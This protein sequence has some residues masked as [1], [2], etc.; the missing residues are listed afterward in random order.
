MANIN[1]MSNGIMILQIFNPI[2]TIIEIKKT[3]EKL[4]HKEVGE[5]LIID[6]ARYKSHPDCKNLICFVYDPERRI[7][8]PRGIENDLSKTTD[9]LGV[10]VFIRPI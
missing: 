3:R 9:G 7:K 5:Q 1:I 8:N 10:K 2:P 4:T 6:I